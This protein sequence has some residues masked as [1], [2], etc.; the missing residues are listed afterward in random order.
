MDIRQH[1]TVVPEESKT[2]TVSLGTASACCLVAA[3]QGSGLWSKHRGLTDLSQDWSWGRQ[4]GVSERERERAGDQGRAIS[5][6][7]VSH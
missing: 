3:A 7:L 1:G 6:S 2:E 4:G 5:Q